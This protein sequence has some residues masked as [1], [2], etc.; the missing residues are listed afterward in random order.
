M[1]AVFLGAFSTATYGLAQDFWV[2]LIGRLLWMV[3]WAGIWV[4]GNAIILEISGEAVR[5]R[6]VGRYH[7]TF[8]LG[9]T[10]GFFLGGF[11]TDQLGY[12]QTMAVH[13][14]LTL[15]GSLVALILLPET[16]D[17]RHPP[18]VENI[19]EQRPCAE[20][21]LPD[22]TTFVS[23]TAL[24]SINRL[25]MAGVLTSTLGLFIAQR[26]RNPIPIAGH[27][28]GVATLTGIALGTSTLISIFSAPV[29]G[30][31]FDW[32]DNRW[33]TVAAGLVPSILDSVY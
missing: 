28:F 5:G 18:F 27:M 13:A 11:L 9:A 4:G 32:A 26:L 15:F 21:R 7:F 25:V 16:K 22:Q 23:A 3:S 24:F 19:Q 1:L 33:R 6:W 8:F 30:A 20:P 17:T 2:L 31:L 10:L 29:W 14:G 12:H